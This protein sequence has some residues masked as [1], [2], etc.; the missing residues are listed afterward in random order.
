MTEDPRTVSQQ[1]DALCRRFQ[2]LREGTEPLE[3]DGTHYFRIPDLRFRRICGLPDFWKA[4]E[5]EA[6]LHLFEQIPGTLVA[7]NSIFAYLLC[8]TSKGIRVYMGATEEGIGAVSVALKGF[9]PG[10]ELA[11]PCTISDIRPACACG[12]VILGNPN[13]PKPE[14]GASP[15]Q[16]AADCICR[17]MA[18]EKFTFLV[19]AKRLP[20]AMAFRF[21]ESVIALMRNMSLHQRVEREGVEQDRGT[22]ENYD[23]QE[24]LKNLE[25]TNELLLHALSSGLWQTAAYYAADSPAVAL[26]LQGILK[27]VFNAMS[28]SVCQPVVCLNMRNIRGAIYPECAF[29]MD[30]EPETYLSPIRFETG[31]RGTYWFND[32][33]YQTTL[34]GQQ[35]G[36]L[37]RLP[38]HE[39]P[40]Y[41]IDSYV[42]FD[43]C[44]R[45]D[46]W[47][48]EWTRIGTVTQPGRGGNGFAN[49]PYGLEMNDFTRHILVIGITGGGKS[50]TSKSLLRTLWGQYHKPF[51]VIESA[52]REYHELMKL[53]PPETKGAFS[54]LC[55][56]TMG[57]DNG[58]PYRINPFECVPGVGLQTH[59]DYVL[60]SF[61]A[62]FDMSPPM[63]YVLESSVFEIY[64]DR[65]WDI[66]TG[67]NLFGRCDYPTLTDLYYK[68]DIVVDRMG[69]YVEVQN[70]VKAAL[71]ARVNS[72]R[73]GGKGL[74]MDTPLSIPIGSLL[75]RPVVLE[76]EDLADD[77]TKSF[78][79]GILMVQLYEYRKAQSLLAS[80]EPHKEGAQAGK[81]F[82]HLLVIEEAHR[83]LKRVDPGSS[84]SRAKSVEFFC[85]ML[86]EIRSYGQGMMICDQVPTKLASDVMKNTNLK[87]IHRT[88]MEEDRHAVG[89]AMNMTPEQMEYLSSLRRGCAAAFA[90]GDNR[91]KLIMMP[92]VEDRATLSRDAI[93][94]R[95]KANIGGSFPQVYEK[96]TDHTLC[97]F[98][99]QPCNRDIRHMV[100]EALKREP[101]EMRIKTLAE[102]SREEKKRLKSVFNYI[103]LVRLMKLIEQKC[104]RK[105]EAQEW[106]CMAGV[107]IDQ[108]PLSD[109]ERF[110]LTVD[111]QKHWSR[112]YLKPKNR[113]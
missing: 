27:S 19:I 68:I 15:M 48:K 101:V 59:I 94:Q 73:I 53:D 20:N 50:N 93:M 41:Y 58:I 17:G 100:E 105:F 70:N 54:E 99:Q 14:R 65:G 80:R 71:K 62:A 97:R 79:T 67:K 52:K 23:V 38:Q 49:I 57:D 7:Q 13:E 39:Y 88:V 98:C 61:N 69:Y 111:Y 78:V 63:P 18:G 113:R 96:H 104:G 37:C 26:R 81:G 103:Y 112:G 12:G 8:G 60:S 74:M 22:Q 33:L 110:A 36:L 91:P 40:G 77:D 76:L 24:Y 92:L 90:E 2:A 95:S 72:L 84:P 34:S 16:L 46:Y 45:I 87:L 102:R 75:D 6:Y 42:E 1:N 66:T 107:L 35:L 86:A 3:S 5:S 44:S 83:L 29:M 89:A 85:D 55:V 109:S 64:G 10:A 9:L 47:D 25:K 32:M 56:F 108:F 11:E 43:T 106:F 51:L 31:A 30:P 28:D 82:R 4:Q 21:R